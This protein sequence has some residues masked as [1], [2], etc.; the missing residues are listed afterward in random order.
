V[1]CPQILAAAVE[2]TND[3]TTALHFFARGADRAIW[4]TSAALSSSGDG[5]NRSYAAL[6]PFF[7][8]PFASPPTALAWGAGTADSPR[9]VGV[10][11]VSDPDRGV[12]LKT[13]RGGNGLG[14]DVGGPAAGPVAVCLV[15]GARPDLWAVALTGVAHNYGGDNATDVFWSQGRNVPWQG[16]AEFDTLVRGGRPGVVCRRDAF[17]HDV[18]V[19][20][21]ADGAVLHSAWSEP[22]G[23]TR[24][25]NRG[26]KFQGEPLVV[27]VGNNRFDFFGI[28]EDK[29][30]RHFMWTAAG[31]FTPLENLGGSFA[32]VPSAAVTGRDRID[33][34]ALGTSD[35]LQHRTLTGTKWADGWEDLN[36][37]ADSAPL[38]V[39]VT[40]KPAG[41]EEVAVF[42]VGKGGEVNHT[43]WTV[44][45]DLS[46]K[47][48][49]WSS[50]G[51][52]MTTQF[53]S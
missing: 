27:A 15:N 8:G 26:G 38:L 32:S 36:V 43:T 14:L 2:E 9:Q 46:W 24:P 12:R 50:L 37:F 7:N 28:D 30:M 13:L 33:V 40:I 1:F 41:V 31:G 52:N 25:V 49:V 44:S 39:N 22:T 53:L 17:L 4:H 29:A 23:W 45:S 11:A 19:Y 34:V 51:G 6:A 21:E 10:F 47:N 16:S 35:T 5:G 48:L 42:V 20:G 3:A 18:V